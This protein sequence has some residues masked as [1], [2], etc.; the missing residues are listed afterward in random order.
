MEAEADQ[1]QCHHRDEQPEGSARSLAG[2]PVPTS[3]FDRPISDRR[4][5]RL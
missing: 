3:D 4:W 5:V 1:A 2:S